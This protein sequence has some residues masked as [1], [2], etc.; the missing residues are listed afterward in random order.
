MGRIS[1]FLSSGLGIG[2]I[3]KAS[4]TFGTLWG[5][6]LYYLCRG[7]D[8]W[9]LWVGTPI[10]VLLSFVFIH[11]AEKQLGS[12]DSSIIV[13]D[14]IAGYLVA[15]LGISFNFWTAALG[16]GLFRLFDIWK[17]FPIGQ[18]DRKWKGVWGVLCDDLVAGIYANLTVRIFLIIWDF[19]SR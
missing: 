9:V 8:P 15:V 13:L 14:E 6:L 18:I 19:F 11:F 2:Y 5:F 10:F 7:F 3:P 1:L 16:F 12:H 17:P 4:G